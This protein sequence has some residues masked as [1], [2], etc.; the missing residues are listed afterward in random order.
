M[1]GRYLAVLMCAVSAWI[2][3]SGCAEDAAD[4]SP[5]VAAEREWR[6]ERDRRMREPTSWLTI[7]GLFWL[8]ECDNTFGS[9]ADNDIILPEHSA[10][11]KAG[12]FVME[13]GSV[14]VI[15]EEGAGIM[16]NDTA[17]TVKTLRSDAAAEPDVLAL[18]RLRLWIIERGGRLAVRMRDL[19]AERFR[20]YRGLRFYPPK[21]EYIIPATF[22][23][24]PEPKL[25]TLATVVGTEAEVRSPGYLQFEIDGSE[26]RLD[27]FGE[28]ANANQFSLIF[29]DETSGDETYGACRFMSVAAD[30]TGRFELNF[31]RAY[32]PPCAYT[33]YATC[34]LPPPQNDLPVRIEAGEKRYMK[35]H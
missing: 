32:N 11:D 21:E 16:C 27:V 18:G 23:P 20:D 2:V 17:V 26:L 25:I 34:P 3:Y 35:H 5:F 15:A 4:V 19:E 13:R 14:A 8:E 24:Y 30:S 10:P 31:N 22:V 29:K 1:R 28:D 33:P 7:A 6:G 9:A 12:V